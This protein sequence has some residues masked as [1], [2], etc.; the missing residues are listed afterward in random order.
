MEQFHS[1]LGG[2]LTRFTAVTKYTG[3]DHII[4]G[5]F[6]SPIAGNNMIQGKLLRFFTAVLAGVSV[7]VE[8][9]EA[10]QLFLKSGTFD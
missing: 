8:N 5:V 9:L 6:A 7:T 1:G 2:S 10:S 3:A 4:P